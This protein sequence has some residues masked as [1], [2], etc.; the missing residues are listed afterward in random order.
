MAAL[1]LAVVNA[2]LLMWWLLFVAACGGLGSYCPDN[3]CDG[4]CCGCCVWL[5][6]VDE[7]VFVF[8]SDTCHLMMMLES[9]FTIVICL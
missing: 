8:V 1:T 3:Y 7:A 9:S 4:Y 6:V 2:G 5:L